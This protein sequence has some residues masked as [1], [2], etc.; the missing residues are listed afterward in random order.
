MAESTLSLAYA[1]LQASVGGY[2][3]YGY[4][5][6][7]GDTAWSTRQTN[8]IQLAIDSGL[9]QFYTPPLIEGEKVTYDWAFLK[10]V[11]TLALT[12]GASSIPLPDDF[13]GIEG[14]AAMGNISVDPIGEIPVVNP[15]LILAKFDD[16]PGQTGFPEMIAVNWMKGSGQAQG[17]R[18]QL[19][20]YPI[21]DAAYTM[22]IQYYVMPDTVTGTY[23]Y[24]YGGAMHAET[25]K[26]SCL[27]AAELLLDNQR[28]IMFE[29]FMQRLTASI[30]ADRRSKP[31]VGGRNGDSSD[32]YWGSGGLKF[33]PGQ[34]NSSPLVNY[35]GS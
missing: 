15:E 9:R 35:T 20:V 4:G 8:D 18:A 28:G 13:G 24:H 6:A 16:L 26:A 31:Q 10:P 27:A 12:Q 34:P 30:S 29:N 7:K 14:K 25:V 32:D 33:F 17:Q 3:G 19:L 23:P 5:L 22:T 2:L 1:D 21:A 11:A